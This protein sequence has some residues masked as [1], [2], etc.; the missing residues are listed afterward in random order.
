MGIDQTPITDGAI[1]DLEFGT[2]GDPGCLVGHG[3]LQT[4]E[5]ACAKHHIVRRSDDGG[6]P[7]WRLPRGTYRAAPRNGGWCIFR[8]WPPTTHTTGSGSCTDRAGRHCSSASPANATGADAACRARSDA[9][10][11]LG[12]WVSDLD[13]A[14]RD[15]PPPA[16]AAAR[17]LAQLAANLGPD[18]P[19]AATLTAV[20]RSDDPHRLCATAA[21]PSPRNDRWM[22][23]AYP[24]YKLPFRVAPA[25]PDDDALN[26]LQSRVGAITRLER[27]PRR[28][29]PFQ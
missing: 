15:G 16:P 10:R 7:D 29:E 28:A 13:A 23:C 21:H 5:W 1:E 4:A 18:E 25:L 20:A 3:L 2:I 22:R 19:L 26:A 14:C 12:R 27:R 24:S 9:Y 17:T 6:K 8:P 11:R